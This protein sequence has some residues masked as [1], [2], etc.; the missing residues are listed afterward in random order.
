MSEI[1]LKARYFRLILCRANSLREKTGQTT[2]GKL[3]QFWD[4]NAVGLFLQCFHKSAFW[5]R[6][7][8]KCWILFY[9]FSAQIVTLGSKLGKI[10][11][12]EKNKLKNFKQCSNSMVFCSKYFQFV[13]FRWK[14]KNF[15]PCTKCSEQFLDIMY[16]T[17]LSFVF[18]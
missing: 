8:F 14:K 4:P 9:I 5:I 17:F 7:K 10:L 13:E 15:G 11:T 12:H 3:S 1:I 2:H 16:A 18:W 6:M